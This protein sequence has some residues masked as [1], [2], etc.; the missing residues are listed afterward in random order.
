M[1]QATHGPKPLFDNLGEVYVCADQSP[2]LCGLSKRGAFQLFTGSSGQDGAH[3]DRFLTQSR[4]VSSGHIC[5]KPAG[6]EGNPEFHLVS[7]PEFMEVV[8]YFVG[9]FLA[10]KLRKDQ[11]H[12][13]VQCVKIQRAAAKVG[14]DAIILDLFGLAM[15]VGMA[16]ERF[17]VLL[18]EPEPYKAAWGKRFPRAI[19]RFAPRQLQHP[20]RF[21]PACA[22]PL[23][24]WWK[25]ITQQEYDELKRLNPKS[26]KVK[27]HQFIR[28]ELQDRLA[29]E[30]EIVTILA[31]QS[32]SL[33]DL[34]NRIRHHYMGEPLQGALFQH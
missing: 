3:W 23:T 17:S 13:G 33:R 18:Q 22:G 21:S 34:K 7:T 25:G 16:A 28:P 31:E 15:P 6:S 10:G 20:E 11:R 24:E 4:V 26:G 27:H 5:R 29:Q 14:I 2:P 19:N 32:F 12:I 1:I 8:D 9:Q 30:R